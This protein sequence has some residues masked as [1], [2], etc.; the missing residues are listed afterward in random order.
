MNRPPLARCLVLAATPVL[1]LAAACSGGGT[2]AAPATT[3]AEA[4]AAT[5]PPAAAAEA[6]EGAANCASEPTLDAINAAKAKLPAPPEGLSWVVE[7][8]SDGCV[9]LGW[10][11]V[12]IDAPSAGRPNHVLLF[13]GNQYLGTGTTEAYPYATVVGNT[14]SDTVTVEYQW[15]N[16]GDGACCPSGGPATVRYQWIKGKVVMLD[17]LPPQ[18]LG[19]TG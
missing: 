18:V 7:D 15:L 1:A 2:T 3:T 11:K 6:P 12:S 10:A 4:P 5:Q 9:T 8:I 19:S 13:Y 17:E 14:A 16:D